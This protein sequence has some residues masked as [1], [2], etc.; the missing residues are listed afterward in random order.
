MS[1]ST[2][3]DMSKMSMGEKLVGGG[4]VLYVIWVFVPTWY[5]CCDVAGLGSVSAGGVN[6]FRGFMILAW[7]VA[8]ATI[9]EIGL[10]NFGSTGLKLPLP[11]GQ[12]HMIGGVVALVCT[13]LGL[14]IK[15]SAFE[16][17]ATLSWGIFVG[18]I[19]A[20]AWAYGGFTMKGEAG[21]VGSMPPM[22][23]GGAP[24]SQ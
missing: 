17:S 14:L 8:L 19:I 23:A 12:L 9:A 6:G 10:T 16:V 24:P 13:I 1:Q 11:R 22:D 4:A 18:L 20:A 7:L 3:F 5:S 15:P 2:G 21:T